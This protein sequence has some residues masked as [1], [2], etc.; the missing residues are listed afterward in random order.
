MQ[1]QSRKGKYEGGRWNARVAG[2]RDKWEP[3]CVGHP[4]QFSLNSESGDNR[5]RVGTEE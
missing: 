4:T 5:W 1:D 3:N 2:H